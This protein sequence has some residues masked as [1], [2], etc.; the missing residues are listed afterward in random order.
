[1]VA[2]VA[3][4]LALN[5]LNRQFRHWLVDEVVGGVPY[6]LDHLVFL[7]P[8]MLVAWGLIGLLM[9]DR[10]DLA[11]CRPKQPREAWLAASVSGLGLSALVIVLLSTLGPVAFDP[12]PDWP[13]LFANFASNFYEEFIYRGVVLGLLLAA[14]DQR[15]AWLAGLI[16]ALLFCQ[17]HLHYPAP[18]VASVFVAGV[19]WAWLTIRYRSLWPAWFSHTLA[20]TIIDNLFKA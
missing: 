17:G 8:L 20:D 1:M 7:V 6:W 13:V 3:L 2:I 15:R 14:L 10:R 12:H 11:L 18:L 19:A 5:P 16:S 4:A 9:L